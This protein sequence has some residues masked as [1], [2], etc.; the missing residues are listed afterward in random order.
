MGQIYNKDYAK[1]WTIM[2]LS[3]VVIIGLAVWFSKLVMARTQSTDPFELQAVVT[4]V[5]N[6]N[7][8]TISLCIYGL[9]ALSAYA[10]TQAYFKAK[11]ISE[12]EPSEPS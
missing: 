1:G 9:I 11:E 2:G 3:T 12:K 10:I 7:G 6:E 5:M 4:A 8:H